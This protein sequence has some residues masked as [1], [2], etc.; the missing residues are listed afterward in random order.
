ML[1]CDSFLQRTE[2][3]VA[4]V[5]GYLV[6]TLAHFRQLAQLTTEHLSEL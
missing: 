3:G 2:K 4:D 5:L 6:S 1:N